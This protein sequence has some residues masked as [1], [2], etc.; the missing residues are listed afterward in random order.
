[1]SSG[2]EPGE[3]LSP[4]ALRFGIV[5][6]DPPLKE[7]EIWHSGYITD[8]VRTDPKFYADSEV[9]DQ[10]PHSLIEVNRYF[11]TAF[12]QSEHQAGIPQWTFGPLMQY[13]RFSDRG[14]LPGGHWRP[15]SSPVAATEDGLVVDDSES[16]IGTELI[17]VN[18]DSW[19][20]FLRRERWYDTILS[21][22][23]PSGARWSV[24]QPRIWKHLSLS[25]ELFNRMLRA[26]IHDQHPVMHTVLF[27]TLMYWRE[28]G[29]M[30]PM[31]EPFPDARV[32]LSYALYK[33]WCDKK[34][35]ECPAEGSANL[36]SDV[37]EYVLEEWLR[38]LMWGFEDHP[39]AVGITW[40]THNNVVTMHTQ[41]LE[42]LA[43]GDITAAER[44]HLQYTIAV[45]LFHELMHALMHFRV[46]NQYSP[47]DPAK[48]WQLGGEPF[49][50]YDPVAEMG[51]A[52][53]SRV[54]GGIPTSIATDS[55]I[56][57]GSYVRFWPDPTQEGG[58]TA[59]GYM[60]DD[61]PTF[62]GTQ[63]LTMS[64]ISALYTSKLLS[65][66][67][68]DDETI[69][70]KSDNFFHRNRLIFSTTAYNRGSATSISKYA[71]DD[72]N[73]AIDGNEPGKKALDPG[74]RE[75]IDSWREWENIWRTVHEP[76]YD[77]AFYSWWNSPW[78][79]VP[80]LRTLYQ[81]ARDFRAGDEPGCAMA[82]DTLVS[83]IDWTVDADTY[84]RALL[85]PG[86]SNWIT[87][88]I[89]LL[90]MA[91]MPIR[92]ERIEYNVQIYT[93][94]GPQFIP[95]SRNPKDIDAL[96]VTSGPKRVTTSCEPSQIYSPLGEDEANQ[97][98]SDFEHSDILLQVHKIIVAITDAGSLVSAPWVQEII[99][100]F[101]DIRIQREEMKKNDP[102][103]HLRLWMP[104]WD[105]KLP[106]YDPTQ[107]YQWD[108]EAGTFRLQSPPPNLIDI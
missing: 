73:F 33:E 3:V 108:A 78:A 28:G 26:L 4:W 53:E 46:A 104:T 13:I 22:K 93:P 30:Q 68:W 29:E 32:L 63:N 21:N 70:R 37:W 94:K 106:D 88:S 89:G 36:P 48:P 58:K 14:L 5:E 65:R 25:L 55:Y 83:S 60:L 97:P 105:F 20:S 62:V 11:H 85:L 8:P 15:E 61:H 86:S 45:T 66:S 24:D 42:T 47:K 77:Q 90:M 35:S 84:R 40:H 76:W 18:E 80:D 51:Y 56:P 1:M 101:E 16:V 103:Y 87:H 96:Y 91:S 69:L 100:L 9:L 43:S 41:P 44:C 10:G 52:V 64:P 92:K 75:M 31:P 67:F 23:V 2:V 79:V 17:E 81:F 102:K 72:T 98:I 12:L 95:S 99:R 71:V 34:G 49:I 39:G 7:D 19:F 107:N 6:K 57:L 54:L 38:S 82:C 59:L 74:E 27:G 50:D